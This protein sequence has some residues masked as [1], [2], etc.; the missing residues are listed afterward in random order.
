[1]RETLKDYLY[2]MSSGTIA[3]LI[4]SPR[5]ADIEKAFD[6]ALA[7]IEAEGISDS[8]DWNPQMIAEIFKEVA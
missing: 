5:Y 8:Y 3:L 7:R 2:H 4:G 6:A 1:M